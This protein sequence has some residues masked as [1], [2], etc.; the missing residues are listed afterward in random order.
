MPSVCQSRAVSDRSLRTSNGKFGTHRRPDFAEL[1]KCEDFSYQQVK[2]KVRLG[3]HLKR[4]PHATMRVSTRVAYA[5]GCLVVEMQRMILFGL[6][7]LVIWGASDAS[8][9]EFSTA[10]ND[11]L[12][13]D[14]DPLPPQAV[15]R[16]PPTPVFPIWVD[17]D[18]VIVPVTVVN[19]DNQI[20]TGL[21]RDNFEIFDDKVKQE[22]LS[23]SAE[24]T[25]VAVGMIFDTSGSMRDKI[26][27]SKDAALQFLTTSNPEDQFMLVTFSK[28][29]Y[30]ISNLAGN[31]EKL[32]SGLLFVTPSGSTSLLDA[33]YLGL[34]VIRKANTSR[35]ALLVISDGGDNHS[36]YSFKSVK[37]A[38]KESDVQIFCMGIF[39]FMAGRMNTLD[40]AAGP[41]LL[42][43]LA[44]ISG[45]RMF[46]VED[47]DE[48][49]DVAETISRELRNQY[50]VEYKPSNLVRDGR[51]RHTKVKLHP[52]RGMPPLRVYARTGYYAPTK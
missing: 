34:A 44:R 26:H 10:D 52:P 9:L 46:S 51:W 50:L 33:I 43:I 16:Q 18:R 49:P 5:W 38:V 4:I 47:P 31:Y 30:L 37:K 39:G 42:S 24:D 41:T 8:N 22:I 28:R 3:Y 19:L 7:L 45:G 20:V 25:P 27:K 23:F 36:R 29:P 1:K 12:N 11:N 35:K 15:I 40:E 21:D 32:L 2:A 17:V 6:I 13:L 14:K 48:L